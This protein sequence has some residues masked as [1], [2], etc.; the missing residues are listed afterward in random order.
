MEI[1]D[2]IARID[3]AFGCVAIYPPAGMPRLQPGHTLPHDLALFYRICAGATLFNQST[4]GIRIVSPAEFVLANPVIVGE[5]YEDDISAAWYIFAVTANREY[6]TMDLNAERL[7]RCYDS[8]FDRHAVAG[9]C[10]IVSL[11]FFEFL[12]R[13]LYNEGDYWYWLRPDFNRLGDAYG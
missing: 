6:I 11:S 8:F 7:G 4:Y 2:L 9:S 12:E 5:Q 1:N 3:S 13:F 10:A